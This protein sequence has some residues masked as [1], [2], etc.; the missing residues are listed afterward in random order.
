MA[1][2]TKNKHGSKEPESPSTLTIDVE[3]YQTYL[4]DMDIPDEKKREL[5]ETIYSIV[6]QFVE[7]GFGITTTD[8]ALEAQ[9]KH[10][11][12]QNSPFN[13]DSD[14]IKALV[15]EEENA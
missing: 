13:L 4:D 8:Q 1:N 12:T 2:T 14:T 11:G 10:P 7:L 15:K 6:V 5:V 3:H 9:K